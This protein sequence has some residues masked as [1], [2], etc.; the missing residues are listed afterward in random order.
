MPNEVPNST[1]CARLAASRQ[2]VEQGAGFARHR[3]RNVFQPAVEFGVIGFALHQP[4][5]RLV[6]EIGEGL[7]GVRS[8]GVGLGE[9]A[10]QQRRQRGGGEGGHGAVSGLG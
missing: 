5:L 6:G 1:I 2:H 10:I 9:Q 4:C 7:V 3:E 8:G